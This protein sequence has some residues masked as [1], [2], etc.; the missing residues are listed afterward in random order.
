MTVKDAWTRAEKDAARAILLEPSP[1]ESDGG[2]LIGR[3]P[4]KIPVEEF[5]RAG[6][7]VVGASAGGVSDNRSMAYVTEET[8]RGLVRDADRA[9]A[10]CI[11]IY[12]TGVAGAQLADELER[13]YGKP[14]FDSVAVT[15]WKAL[16][17]IGLELRI[18]G[19]GSL[20]SGTLAP[21]SSGLVTTPSTPG[22]RS[23]AT[24]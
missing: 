6:H 17:M 16:T 14:V 23:T 19:W 24:G 21:S 7:D 9:T 22:L 5:N 1:Y 15:L 18:D 12:C 8:V 2:E 20:L 13:A 10:D 11:L 4:R 3:D